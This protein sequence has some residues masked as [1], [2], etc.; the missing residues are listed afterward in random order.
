MAGPRYTI[1]QT[2]ARV[3]ALEICADHLAT[4]ATRDEID[5]D[6]YRDVI[7]KLINESTRLK[8]KAQEVRNRK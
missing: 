8:G 3:A 6:Q 5:R 7:K 1:A 4:A 2:R